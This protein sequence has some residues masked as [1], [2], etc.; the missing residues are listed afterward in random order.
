MICSKVDQ[1]TPI[2]EFDNEICVKWMQR[3]YALLQRQHM[4][5]LLDSRPECEQDQENQTEKDRP[6]SPLR[7]WRW[8]RRRKQKGVSS[9]GHVTR[10]A[11]LYPAVKRTGAICNSLRTNRRLKV[12]IRFSRVVSL[13]IDS[14]FRRRWRFE[15]MVRKADPRMFGRASWNQ[16][17]ICWGSMNQ[18]MLAES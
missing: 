1:V 14:C 15:N 10:E 12:R 16:V 3:L 6:P 18:E 9:Q 2:L 4:L 11:G 8:R 13:L 17:I 7:R 5:Q